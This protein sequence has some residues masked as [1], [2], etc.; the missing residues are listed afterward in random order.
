MP[1]KETLDPDEEIIEGPEARFQ[2]LPR[3]AE[4]CF[5][6]DFHSLPQSSNLCS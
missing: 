2:I 3:A 1:S 6:R 4:V 5:H